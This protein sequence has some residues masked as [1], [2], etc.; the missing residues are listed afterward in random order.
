MALKRSGKPEQESRRRRVAAAVV[1]GKQTKVIAQAEGLTRRRVQR[2]A[3]QPATRLLIAE[4]MQPHHQK[5]RELAAEAVK[6]VERGLKAKT[7]GGR[8]EH[9]I[10]LRAVGRFGDLAHL[11][12]GSD[13]PQ[14]DGEGLVTWQRFIVLYEQREKEAA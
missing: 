4:L 3:A 5:L 9:E 11:A 8:H 7:S 14:G 10:Q 6:A 2:I 1:A 13:R 12:Q